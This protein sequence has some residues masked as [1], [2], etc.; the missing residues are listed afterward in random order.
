MVADNVLSARADI[1]EGRARP[2]AEEQM[3]FFDAV[4]ELARVL[5]TAPHASEKALLWR[6][7]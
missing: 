7:S 3:S 4:D 1:R 2:T 5:M 6:V